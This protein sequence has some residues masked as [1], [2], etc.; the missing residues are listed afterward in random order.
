MV[1]IPGVA[2]A[3]LLLLLLLAREDPRRLH[4]QPSDGVRCGR[5]GELL[6]PGQPFLASDVDRRAEVPPPVEVE[7]VVPPRLPGFLDRSE[8]LEEPVVDGLQ[9]ESVGGDPIVEARIQAVQL[10]LEQ[11]GGLAEVLRPGSDLGVGS[12]ARRLDDLVLELVAFQ[13]RLPHPS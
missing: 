5:D 1:G 11:G 7:Q 4:S 10:A 6:Q 9:V 2:A 3:L 13:H 8:A 12:A